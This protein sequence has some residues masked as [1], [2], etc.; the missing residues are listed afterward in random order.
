MTFDLGEFNGKD[1]VFVGVGKGRA[2]AG[3]QPFLEQYAQLKSFTGVDKQPGDN[4]LAF[5]KEYDQA[6]TIFVKNEGIPGTDMPVPYITAMQLFFQLAHT[7]GLSTVGITGTKGKSTTTAL[8]AHLLKEGGE[9]VVLAGNIGVSPL[10][11]LTDATPDTVFVLELSSYQ[12]SDLHLSPHI[13]ACINLYNDHTDWHGSLESYWEA[14]HNI[15]RF[16]GSDDT[17]IYNPDFPPL[18]DWAAAA[19]CKTI[20]VNPSEPVDL[21]GAQLFGAH[22]GLNYLVAREIARQ[23]GVDDAVSATALKSFVPLRHRMQV[24][25]TKNTRTY[26]DDAIGMTPESTT[27]SLK[28]VSETIGPVGCLLLGG[29]DRNYDFTDVMKLI[30]EHNVPHLV[31]FPETEAKMKAALPAG[32]KPEIFET[33][34]MEDAVHYAAEHAP[35]NSVVLLSTAAPSYLLWKDFEDKGDRFQDAVNA[36]G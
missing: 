31:L 3:I 4:P 5:L 27:A 9:N 25:A 18:R 23:F 32:Y 10:P 7:H 15:M 24:V 1:V 29:Q 19:H 34:S 22:N 36:L 11:A 21:S 12:L 8:T 33:K 6:S 35:E 14:K 28:A 16:A 30:A 17:F 2:A 20:A 13:S 26:I